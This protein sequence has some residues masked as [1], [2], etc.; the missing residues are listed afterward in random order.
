MDS[1]RAPQA[2]APL[3]LADEDRVRLNRAWWRALCRSSVL[4]LVLVVEL[5]RGEA[6][7]QDV[8]ADGEADRCAQERNEAGHQ[9][10]ADL[11]RYLDEDLPEDRLE[12][13]ADWFSALPGDHADRASCVGGGRL[14]ADL[15]A[16]RQD[17][18]PVGGVG[19]RV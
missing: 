10:G 8:P 2:S 12:H 13:V 19:Q 1:D 16:Q 5:G 14:G 6:F 3:V 7:A 4:N 15:E 9:L 11:G 18:G 17:L